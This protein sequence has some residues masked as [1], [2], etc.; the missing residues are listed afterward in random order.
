MILRCVMSCAIGE[1][2][3]RLWFDVIA[4]SISAEDEMKRAGGMKEH[5]KER[6]SERTEGGSSVNDGL[7]RVARVRCFCLACSFFFF[8]APGWVFSVR[9]VPVLG[10]YF[11]DLSFPFWQK[12]VTAGSNGYSRSV[13]GSGAARKKRAVRSPA[14]GSRGGGGGGGGSGGSGSDDEDDDRLRCR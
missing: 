4:W 14:P 12:A 8:W 6:G 7:V 2:G 9:S 1:L 13:F 3:G 10:L 5:G 11:G